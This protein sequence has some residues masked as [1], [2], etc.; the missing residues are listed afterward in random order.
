VLGVTD[1]PIEGAEGNK[2]FLIAGVFS[3]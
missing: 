2:E 1:S 3:G